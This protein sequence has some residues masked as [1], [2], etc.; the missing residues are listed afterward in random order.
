M[1]AQPHSGGIILDEWRRFL[2]YLAA[3]NWS[4]RTPAIIPDARRAHV[5]SR[6]AANPGA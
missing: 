4:Y 3:Q 6:Q 1:V 2:D 5:F